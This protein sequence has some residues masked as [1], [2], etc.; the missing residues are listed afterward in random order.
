M[1]R[2]RRN[3]ADAKRVQD[4]VFAWI[5][6]HPGA[7]RADCGAALGLSAEYVS[8]A[9]HSARVARGIRV[10]RTRVRPKGTLT[11]RKTSAEYAST[12]A[13]AIGV[14]GLARWLRVDHARAQSLAAGEG[15]AT[16][17]EMLA[18]QRGH[19]ALMLR[20]LDVSMSEL[21]LYDLLARRHR[22]DLAVA[23]AESRS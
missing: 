21:A 19:A 17:D 5:E 14:D 9:L 11:E 23:F 10:K 18:L 1:S 22:S 20:T 15:Y 2:T 8:Q 6:A 12:V 13:D 16:E 4:E 7:S 3:P